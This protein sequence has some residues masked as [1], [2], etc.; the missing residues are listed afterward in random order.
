M[1]CWH[2]Q[3]ENKFWPKLWPC[4]FYHCWKNWIEIKLRIVLK[5]LTRYLGE[6]LSSFIF[7]FIFFQTLRV[8]NC[9]S[10]HI[11]CFFWK[12]CIVCYDINLFFQI[13][14]RIYLHSLFHNKFTPA[15]RRSDVADWLMNQQQSLTRQWFLNSF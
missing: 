13:L 1:H 6:F 15:D 8:F 7:K 14:P 3:M 4:P 5:M 12:V 10:F 9:L 2:K 11:C